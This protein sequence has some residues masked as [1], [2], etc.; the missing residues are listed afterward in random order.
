MSRVEGQLA[1]Q[2]ELAKQALSWIVF[3]KRPLSTRELQHALAT[4]LG[5]SHLREDNLP[6]IEDVV[7]ACAGLV[8]V[9]EESGII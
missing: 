4:E 8:A 9:D 6:E 2:E 1:D 7:S 5:D 3:A